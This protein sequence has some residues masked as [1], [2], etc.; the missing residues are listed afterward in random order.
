MRVMSAISVSFS[1]P[2]CA[3]SWRRYCSQYCHLVEVAGFQFLVKIFQGVDRR[4]FVR[5]VQTMHVCVV[6]R[7][8]EEHD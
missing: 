7:M 2:A 8:H 5:P 1:A 6:V 4:V 3:K